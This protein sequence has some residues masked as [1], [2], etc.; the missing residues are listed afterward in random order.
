[1]EKPMRGKGIMPIFYVIY[2]R[3]DSKF[4]KIYELIG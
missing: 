2:R 4:K 1:M 3:L